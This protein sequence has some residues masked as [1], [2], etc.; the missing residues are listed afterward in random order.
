MVRHNPVLSS[1]EISE[2]IKWR[3]GNTLAPHRVRTAVAKMRYNRKKPRNVPMLTQ[4]PI[5]ARLKFIKEKI[6]RVW[7]KMMLWG[8]FGLNMKSKL[9]SIEGTMTMPGEVYQGMLTEHVVSMVKG[10]KHGAKSLRIGQVFQQDNY[11]WRQKSF[12][13]NFIF[14]KNS[15]SIFCFIF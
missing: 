13:T 12:D 1:S 2:K 3:P 14:N 8:A 10:R 7:S 11:S 4:Q 6:N 5:E 15:F 9:Q